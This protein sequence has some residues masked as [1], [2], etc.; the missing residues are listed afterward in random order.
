MGFNV[1]SRSRQII[2]VSFI[3]IFTNIILVAVKVTIG[4]FTNSLAVMLDALNNLSDSLSSLVTIVGTKL[5]TRAPDKKHPYGYGRIE[6]ITAIVIGAI[7]F[8]AGATALK[9]SIA[10][11]ITPEETNYNITA[12]VIIS[13]GIVVKYGLGRFVKNSGEELGS[14]ALIASGTEALFD[15]VLAIGTLFCAILSFFWNITIDAFLG[16]V[17]ALGIMKSGFDRLK[18]T[19]DNIIGVRADEALTSKIK[20]HIRRYQGVVGAYDLILHNYGP[21]EIIGSVHIEVPDDMTAREIH[22]LTRSIKADI[23]RDFSI[24][25]TIGVY[26]ANDS[27]PYVAK[28]KADLLRILHSY[29]EILEFHAF[30]VDKELKQVTFDLIFDFETKN[31]ESLKEEIIQRI[32]K[33][34]S[35]FEFSIVV[36][37]DFSSTGLVTACA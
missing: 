11:I 15:S 23:M 16:A 13:I 17:I 10:K 2:N 22:R 7:I 12:I 34:Y 20:C 37:P 25:M 35:E 8:L 26:A 14:Q 5:A 24:E 31:V 9:E 21:T 1:V 19:L 28:L 4:F 18:E 6:Y 3:S 29:Q 33:D 27:E 30:Y 36:D 32:K